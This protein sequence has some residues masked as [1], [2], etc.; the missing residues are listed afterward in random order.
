MIETG[1]AKSAPIREF[2][3]SN[4]D[5]NVVKSLRYVLEDALSDLI[6]ITNIDLNGNVGLQTASRRK[7]YDT[8]SDLFAKIGMEVPASPSQNKKSFR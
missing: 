8:V 5:N 1:D 7:A 6:D 4:P 2:I 3:K